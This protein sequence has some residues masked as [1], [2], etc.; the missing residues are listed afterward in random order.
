V[1][2]VTFLSGSVTVASG[3]VGLVYVV[4]VLARVP[5]ALVAHPARTTDRK[6]TRQ[7]QLLFVCHRLPQ[8]H[9]ASKNAMH[10]HIAAS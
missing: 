3:H 6:T 8:I 10:A 1:L 5:E 9:A 7:A 4:I 2:G